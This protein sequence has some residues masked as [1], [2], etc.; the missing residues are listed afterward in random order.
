M[1]G[2]SAYG[3]TNRSEKGFLMKKF[4]KDPVRRSLWAAKVKRENWKPTDTSVLCEV[5]FDE[6]MWEKTRE[7]G[8][9]KLK[10]NANS[11]CICPAK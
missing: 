9:R 1:V 3:C 4:P 8:S 11:F 5:H 6:S 7:D 2:C 10:V